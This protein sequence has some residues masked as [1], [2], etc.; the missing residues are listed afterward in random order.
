MA[1]LFK[2]LK[3]KAHLAKNGFDLSRKHVFSSQAGMALPCLSLET[4]PGDHFE[5][6]LAALSRTQTFNTAAFLRGKQ[7]YDFFFVPYTQLWHPFNQFIT[8]RTDKH[9][10]NQKG[11]IFAPVIELSS[12]LRFIYSSLYTDGSSA[13]KYD[14]MNYRFADGAIRILDLLGYGDYRWL[15]SIQPELIEGYLDMY[16]GKYVNVFRLAAYQ[17]IW[18]DYYRNKFY[19]VDETGGI[20]SSAFYNSFG[21]Y[22]YGFNFDDVDCSTFS[23]SHIIES[24]QFSWNGY[25]PS[26]AATV[27]LYNLLKLNYIQWKKDIYTTAMPSQQFGAISSISFGTGGDVTGPA[28]F[29]GVVSKV[30]DISGNAQGNLKAVASGQIITN[31]GVFSGGDVRLEN[32]HSHQLPQDSFSFDV[33]QL[34]NEP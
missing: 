27:R 1:D 2:S 6:D 15:L 25:V 30:R 21:N 22:I 34:Q 16:T 10:S 4:V 19:D 24:D 12:L 5:I 14:F 28:A 13:T 17:H 33:L 29:D 18:Y 32:S 20:S 7:R 26:N 8:Q 3:P 9:S 31:S 23:Q 11:H